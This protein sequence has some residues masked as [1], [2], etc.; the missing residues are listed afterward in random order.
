MIMHLINAVTTSQPHFAALLTRQQDGFYILFVIQCT[1]YS[2]TK[3]S[4]VCTKHATAAHAAVRTLL[5]IACV[6]R[7]AE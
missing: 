1:Q 6:N 4:E 5:G 7:L 3:P 2:Q